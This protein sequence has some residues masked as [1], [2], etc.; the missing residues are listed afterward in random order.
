MAIDKNT[1]ILQ[2]DA[3]GRFTLDG[4][5]RGE[6]ARMDISDVDLIITTKNGNH[7]VVPGGGVSAMGDHPPDVIF[8]DGPASTA[9]LLGEVGTA[10]SLDV[11]IAVPSSL[12]L[13]GDKGG[14]ST[15]EDMTEKVHKLEHEKE[16]QKKQIEILKRKLAEQQKEQKEQHEK[17]QQKQHDH[18]QVSALNVNT[19]GTVEQMVQSLERLE[20]NLHR[21]DYDYVPPHK[22]EISPPPSPPAGGVPPPISLTPI[23]TLF[24][25]NVVGTASDTT[26]HAGYTTYYGG[27]GVNGSDASAQIGPRN[28]AQYSA[29]TIS[30]NASTNNYV[31]AE[32]LVSGAAGLPN[33]ASVVGATHEYTKQFVLNVAGYF[34][35]LNDI[36]IKNVPAN[37][38]ILG[39]TNQGGG[40]W[41]LPSSYVT[42]QNTFT[43]V[44]STANTGNFTLEFDVTGTST[45]GATFTSVQTFYFVYSAV[46]QASDVTN[47]S[48]DFIQNN[49]I[50]ETYILPTQD[51]PN[52][53]T[54]A[55]NT[56]DGTGTTDIVY[57]GNNTDTITLQNSN[58]T[59]TDG[60]G[61]GDTITVGNGTNTI[62]VGNGTNDSVTVGSG[63]N[64]IV[65]GNG[66]GVTVTA[67]NGINTI[68]VGNGTGNKITVGTGL[69]N[70]TVGSGSGIITAG[71]NTGANLD[72]ITINGPSASA[73]I[74]YTVNLNNTTSLSANNHVN[75]NGD[76]TNIVNFGTGGTTTV[77]ISPGSSTNTINTGLGTG[78]VI[79]GGNGTVNTLNL[80]TAPSSAGGLTIAFSTTAGSA[81]GTGV[82]DTFT[83]VTTLY[84]SN[85]GDTVTLSNAGLTFHGGSGNNTIT[86]T[87]GSGESI[88]VGGGS[89][90]ITLASGG[91]NSV[92]AG[93][94]GN[95]IS[96]LGGGFNTVYGGNGTNTFT[97]ANA[98]ASTGNK[99]YGG[100]GNNT[101]LSPDAGTTYNGTNG[102]NL[103]AISNV[104]GLGTHN[105]NPYSV[106][107][108]SPTNPFVAGSTA[109]VTTPVTLFSFTPTG[110]TANNAASSVT[111][112]Y[113]GT[114]AY[115]N[116]NLGV[117]LNKIDYSG[118]ATPGMTVNLASGAGTGGTA[119][120]SSY[121]STPITGYDSI[122]YVIG[123]AGGNNNNFNYLYSSYSDTV[124]QAPTGS[125]TNFLETSFVDYSSLSSQ[126]V[127]MIGS[128]YGYNNFGLGNGHEIIVSYYN[129]GNISNSLFYQNTPGITL[130]LSNSGHVDPVFNNYIIPAFSGYNNTAANTPFTNGGV[131][132]GN[133]YFVPTN[134]TETGIQ[135][136]YLTDYPNSVNV[137]VGGYEGLN[138]IHFNPNNPTTEYFYG[139]NYAGTGGVPINDFYMSHGVSYAVGGTGATNIVQTNG[140]YYPN[141]IAVVILKEGNVPNSD[142]HVG[143]SSF[144]LPSGY[145]GFAY[146]FASSSPST[147]NIAYL[148]NFSDVVGAVKSYI[149]GDDNGDS[150]GTGTASTTIYLGS[151][152]NSV[153]ALLGS[154]IINDA[155]AAGRNLL[156]LTY[157]F[158]IVSNYSFTTLTA[159]YDAFL[160]SSHQ[161]TFF[162]G[163]TGD[164][165]LIDGSYQVASNSNALMS[166]ENSTI[167]V[168]TFV[169]LQGSPYHNSSNGTNDVTG[170]NVFSYDN[171]YSGAPIIQA[172]A[173]DVFIYN[174]DNLSS[175]N[176]NITNPYQ[177]YYAFTGSNVFYATPSEMT[178]FAIVL[179]FSSVMPVD[180]I[181]RVPGWGVNGP[182]DGGSFT[183][184][185][186]IGNLN[187]P[188]GSI[189]VRDL[190][191]LDVRSGTD[192]INK[193][194]STITFGGNSI[195]NSA[196]HP[197]FMLSASDIQ[198]L[199]GN[200]AN[201]AISPNLI[202]KLDNGDLFKPLNTVDTVT[203]GNTISWYNST[204]HNSST[205]IATDTVNSSGYYH[206][207][208]AYNG[209]NATL[210]IHY[211][212][213]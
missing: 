95:T 73:I 98:T 203:A 33:A 179:N 78:N 99:L 35:K 55:A 115:I 114:T 184:A 148:S 132:Q 150:F 109:V 76:G 200:L 213:G 157:G 26:A 96:L 65:V 172:Y 88:Y 128:R 90:T 170:S 50:V 164:A 72:T 1:T 149:V 146:G 28:A 175:Y 106:A 113:D 118:D 44:Y 144:A 103:A 84:G 100:A 137:V 139:G 17:D 129:P 53:I 107:N 153:T 91:G 39:A 60:G 108:T 112:T 195:D 126:T 194:A 64:T 131:W 58:N 7:Y 180:D 48:L 119:N 5:A 212:T 3:Q 30:V 201:S 205:L 62:T 42:K 121:V 59:I 142:P 105:G 120:N 36:T 173:N 125:P 14:G 20:E 168:G 13:E 19:E 57:G 29:A 41:I 9:Q 11:E 197:T 85:N 89:N 169:T 74:G 34:T 61:N 21:S 186:E 37:V 101:F 92:Y 93:N 196:S 136:V 102:A 190:N 141:D 188:F 87:Y 110:G 71:A 16:E 163:G 189:N 183:N 46:A 117:Q 159:G 138:V 56:G 166:T 82:G 143:D 18:D 147:T 80:S 176:S 156:S 181:L 22:F 174:G 2:A 152:G 167:Q 211:G 206:D 79:T 31:Y 97:G 49:K 155:H 116:I 70:I 127:V 207:T 140:G 77:T 193:S 38:S 133:D 171:I 198:Q 158:D 151:G 204:T 122:N 202:L 145:T 160:N 12:H 40:V 154:N 187:D 83:G 94:G 51:Q 124:L 123:G 81:S 43:L 178:D 69:N 25:G 177:Q 10:I 182:M 134:Q 32:G 104:V 66:S 199:T 6:I 8:S 111:Y 192:S 15:K 45:R 165:T 75:I 63:N 67:G 161:T 54:T 27:G 191:V 24:M 162:N 130:N 86:L 4:V 23:V 47:P 208:I 185:F 135:N 210:Q 52:I 68:I 209:S